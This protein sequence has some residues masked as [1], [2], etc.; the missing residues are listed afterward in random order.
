[1]WKCGSSSGD[2]EGVLAPYPLFSDEIFTPLKFC[3]LL[4]PP[5]LV[6]CVHQVL[7]FLG[8]GGDEG[9]KVDNCLC[10]CLASVQQ[11]H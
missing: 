8:G 11:G 10:L 4:L 3:L 9:G 5:F 1:M 6:S 2:P 7:C